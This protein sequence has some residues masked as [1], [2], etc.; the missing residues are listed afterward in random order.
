MPRW[1]PIAF[2]RFP[3]W[4]FP[5]AASLTIIISCAATYSIAFSTGHI[6]GVPYISDTG[7]NPPE[8]CIFG[9]FLTIY[10][11]FLGV[12]VWN[13]YASV[14]RPTTLQGWTCAVGLLAAFGV[15][16][17]ANFQETVLFLVHIS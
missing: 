16:V 7:T 5:Y 4:A 6:S 8:S 11:V 12:S 13:V 2:R 17:V 10:A 15:E 9:L 14:A 1:G 3:A